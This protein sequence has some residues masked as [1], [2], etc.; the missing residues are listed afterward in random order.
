MLCGLLWA[1]FDSSHS[2]VAECGICRQQLLLFHFFNAY[3]P[4]AVTTFFSQPVVARHFSRPFVK[5][6]ALCYHRC[7][8]CLSYLSCLS[9]LSVALVYCGQR[10]GW[11]KMPL[12]TEVDLGPGNIVL[13]GDPSC[14]KGAQHPAAN[15]DPCYCRHTAAWIKMP[16]GME[17]DLS[18][19]HIVLDWDPALPSRRKRHSSPTKRLDGSRCR[20]VRR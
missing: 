16:L 2:T 10:A 17:V 1:Y 20:L 18:P 5:R 6:F 14:K 7:L 15:F 19:G 12:G 9:C 3:T 13:D 8:S 4:Q 11:I